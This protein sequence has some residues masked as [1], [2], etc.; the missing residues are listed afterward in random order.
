MLEPRFSLQ[1]KHNQFPV[2]HVPIFRSKLK[3]SMLELA[4]LA[5]FLLISCGESI[6]S[7]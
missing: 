2:E 6:T 4:K 7:I 5:D 3:K 1:N